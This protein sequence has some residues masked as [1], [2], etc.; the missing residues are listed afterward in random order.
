V[1]SPV[2]GAVESEAEREAVS[3]V[4]SRAGEAVGTAEEAAAVLAG[5]LADS[6]PIA[7]EDAADV[8]DGEGDGDSV[9]SVVLVADAWAV[10]SS[11]VP[12]AAA[13]DAVP[14]D[15]GVGV[16]AGSSVTG[17]A[18]RSWPD[19]AD[20]ADGGTAP[21]LEDTASSAPS[22]ATAGSPMDDDDPATHVDESY[23]RGLG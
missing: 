3:A 19:G 18:G 2:D 1:D 15:A 8:A 13:G 14:G 12:G 11:P 5:A 23:G 10:L 7:P 21:Q 6:A 22:V 20:G 4:V 17:A 16:D 9:P